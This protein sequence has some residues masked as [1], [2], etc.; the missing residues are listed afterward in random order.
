[1]SLYTPAGK[2]AAPRPGRPADGAK[3]GA[4]FR[5]APLDGLKPDAPD[6]QNSETFQDQAAVTDDDGALGVGVCFRCQE[7]K[8]TGQIPVTAQTALGHLVADV[9]Q[10]G[11]R[12]V[13]G[14][15]EKEGKKM[16][17]KRWPPGWGQRGSRYAAPA[18]GKIFLFTK[19][20]TTIEIPPLS[21]VVPML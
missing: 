5:P 11:R 6:R 20:K 7:Q 8:R 12:V 1:M 16:A 3:K 19:K 9:F 2:T 18:E 17:K 4:G 13:E 10:N 21:T 15:R 14:A